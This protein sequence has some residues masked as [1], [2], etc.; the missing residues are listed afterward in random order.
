MSFCVCPAHSKLEDAF[1]LSILLSYFRLP[2]TLGLGILWSRVSVI[3]G[4]YV[5]GGRG[6]RKGGE[7]ERGRGEGKGG[8]EGREEEGEGEE[9]E[10]RERERRRDGEREEGEEEEEE[11]GGGGRG[12]RGRLVWIDST[13]RDFSEVLCST[14]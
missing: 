13:L 12:G 8:R 2:R 7:R 5:E 9:R 10:E 14:V 11:E 6:G 1:L 4:R 3:V